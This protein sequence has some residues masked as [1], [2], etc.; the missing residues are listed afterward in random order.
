[1]S[2]TELAMKRG[3]VRLR[4]PPFTAC[5]LCFSAH[6]VSYL[7]DM[8]GPRRMLTRA[9]RSA[10]LRRRRHC[11]R[12]TGRRSCFWRAVSPCA[13]RSTG[14]SRAQTPPCGSPPSR[15]WGRLVGSSMTASPSHGEPLGCLWW[16]PGTGREGLRPCSH[17]ACFSVGIHGPLPEV[18]R[19]QGTWAECYS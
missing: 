14:V 10:S 4:T 5:L 13:G 16:V 19:R 2:G 17:L 11:G 8:D 3:G 7:H 9:Q 6:I 15:P 12:R 18:L 1:M